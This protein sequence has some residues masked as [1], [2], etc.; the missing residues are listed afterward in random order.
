MKKSG[1]PTGHCR[2]VLYTVFLVGLLSIRTILVSNRTLRSFGPITQPVVRHTNYTENASIKNSPNTPSNK[3]SDEVSS[4]LWLAMQFDRVSN[5][6]NYTWENSTSHRW[7]PP[8]NL[9][10]LTRGD[11]V[12]LFSKENTLW[13]GD[14][15]ARQDYHT[16]Y[17][18]LRETNQ[19]DTATVDLMGL[20]S[21]DFIEAG[22]QYK[23]ILIKNQNVN[24]GG[25]DETYQYW[26]CPARKPNNTTE[27]HWGYLV[28][29]GQVADE[30]NQK[31]CA[32]TTFP[33]P[34]FSIAKLDYVTEKNVCL[35]WVKNDLMI[36]KSL[37]ERYSV[38]VFSVGLVNVGN[39]RCMKRGRT[40]TQQVQDLLDYLRDHIARPDLIV[41]WKV[42]AP[43]RPMFI[44]ATVDQEVAEAS[45]EWFRNNPNATH[46][47]LA[48]FRYGVRERTAE[49]NRIY[50]DHA[51][52]WGLNARLLSIDLVSRIIAR[53]KSQ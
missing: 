44:N 50:G 23:E 17:W 9:P 14:S 20:S 37:F 28:N 49:G 38:M 34:K 22:E 35:I 2:R 30:E 39:K 25:P 41:I 45:L 33:K 43:G 3:A 4:A 32:H 1:G 52:H 42:H 48:D 27:E 29:V 53:T 40:N 19:S 10:H 15:T 36:H 26:W 7:V 11:M 12:Q 5:I 31:L 8:Q 46:M 16:L 18:L 47:K 51:L 24:F 6:A 21:L 13:I